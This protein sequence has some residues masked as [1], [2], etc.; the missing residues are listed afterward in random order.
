M[1]LPE[2]LALDGEYAN[3]FSG[4]HP[5][6][7]VRK[8][9]DA[10]QVLRAKDLPSAEP[11]RVVTVAGLVITRQRPEAANGAVFMTLED[12]TGQVDLILSAGAFARFQTVVRLSS[13]LVARGRLLA[14]GRAR[15]IAVH[16]LARLDLHS[17]HVASH[18]FH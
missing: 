8:Q 13:A 10:E 15:N 7:I 2:L 14:D 4:K 6:E 17:V 12:E 16:A 11:D 3:S 18:D 9:L 1:G 5:M